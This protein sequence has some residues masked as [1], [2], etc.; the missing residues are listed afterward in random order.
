MFI[1]KENDKNGNLVK[2]ER[3][4]IYLRNNINKDTKIIDLIINNRSDIDG[5]N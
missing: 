4:K 1:M 3:W 5:K 2:N